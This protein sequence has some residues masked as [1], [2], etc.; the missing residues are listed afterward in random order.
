MK[1]VTIKAT[2]DHKPRAD[3]FTLIDA[4][5][6]PCPEGGVLA[7]VVHLSLDPY[8]GSRLRGRHMGEAPLEPMKGAVPGAVVG[9]GDVVLADAAA[10]PVGGVA[11]QI[12]R[13]KGPPG[14]SA[15]PE[16]RKN[17]F[18]LRINTASTSVS[19][20]SRKAGARRSPTPCPTG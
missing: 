14:S 3:D 9:E 4:E 15:S 17:A 1:L 7:R 2:V 19:I 16:G 5:T 20:I 10:G 12:A 18:L 11:G 8:V 13:I 6:P